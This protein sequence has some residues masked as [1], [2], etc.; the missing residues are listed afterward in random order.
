MWFL[1]PKS[2][3][4][5]PIGLYCT[6]M[7]TGENLLG[8]LREPLHHSREGLLDIFGRFTCFPLHIK[9]EVESKELCR[10]A[11][12]DFSPVVVETTVAWGSST[13]T[14]VRK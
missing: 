11:G 3:Y 4:L 12:W 7:F 8:S 1:W 13:C 2:C 10:A 14:F 9:P 6:A 5:K